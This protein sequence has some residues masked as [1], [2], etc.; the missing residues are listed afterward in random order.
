M[1]APTPIEEPSPEAVARVR[2]LAERRLSDEEFDAY[3]NAPMSDEERK[4]ILASFT[5]FTKRY[6][7]PGGRLAAARKAYARWVKAMP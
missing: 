3:V 2:A 5:W 4:E 1:T 7:T 6:P